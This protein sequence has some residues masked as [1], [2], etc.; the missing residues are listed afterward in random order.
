MKLNVFF[1][2][3][4]GQF[5]E[6]QD[7]FD[8]KKLRDEIERDEHFVPTLFEIYCRKINEIVKSDYYKDAE[9]IAS[10]FG[11]LNI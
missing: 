7:K 3:N 5:V 8:V 4:N 1:R 9:M 11:P 10:S 2:F 6:V